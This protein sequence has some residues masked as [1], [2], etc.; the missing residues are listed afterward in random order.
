MNTYYSDKELCEK[1]ITTILKLYK[2]HTPL[3]NFIKDDITRVLENIGW[4]CWFADWVNHRIY[5]WVLEINATL[6]NPPNTEFIH[7]EDIESDDESDD[8]E[9]E[10]LVYVIKLWTYNKSTK[11]INYDGL[12]EDCETGDKEFKTEEE[13]REQFEYATEGDKGY[14][15]VS[16]VKIDPNSEDRETLI[17]E[18]EDNIDDY[19]ETAKRHIKL[20]Y[21]NSNTDFYI[22][23]GDVEWEYDDKEVE[24]AYELAKE[25]GKTQDGLESVCIEETIP[26]DGSSVILC[27]FDF[28]E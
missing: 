11:T 25:W 6:P 26:D 28:S 19:V 20:Y 14:S 23:N 7:W 2:I 4:S 13:A 22:Y 24:K 18:W 12:W 1:R 3:P 10:D 16:L 15:A 5:C 27:K 17:E 9:D 8:E 21:S